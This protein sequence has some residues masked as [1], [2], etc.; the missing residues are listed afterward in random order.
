MSYKA[1]DQV[2]RNHVYAIVDE[3]DSVLVDEARTPMILS[4]QADFSS[5]NQRF[6]DWRNKIEGLIREQNNIV[7][8]I[9]SDAEELLG[10]DDENAGIKLLMASRGAPQNNKLIKLMQET[11]V[12]QLITKTENNFLR[13]KNI[14]EID[15]QL[16]FSIDERSGTIGLSDIGRERLSSSNPEQFVIPDIG[17]FFHDIDNKLPGSNINLTFFETPYLTTPE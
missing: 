5:S 1:T 11:G 13:E 6:N 15:E 8:K 4:G 17:E 10:K 14:E 12:I 7:N 16:F 9:I 2:Q 3:V